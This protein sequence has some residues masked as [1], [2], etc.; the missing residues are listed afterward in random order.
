MLF[1]RSV[2]SKDE[3]SVNSECRVVGMYC[4]GSLM[5]SRLP[6][7]PL[8]GHE[9]IKKEFPFSSCGSDDVITV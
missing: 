1:V 9:Q 8:I 7:L 4:R 3:Y 6:R 2:R 5:L